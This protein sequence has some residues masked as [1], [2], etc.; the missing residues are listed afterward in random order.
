MN[1]KTVESLT[2]VLRKERQHF[3]GEFRRAE[4]H[5]GLIAEERE[6]EMEERA[7][8][9][10]S[11]RLLASLDDRTLVAVREIDA[12]LQRLLD[13]SYGRCETVP[14]KNPDRPS[15]RPPGHAL[16]QELRGA[17]RD[18]SAEI[19]W[20]GHRPNRRPAIRPSGSAR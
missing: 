9:E 10:G 2:Q 12:A 15:S 13:E 8:E 6:S 19:A 16:L 20:G 3:L 18:R 1:K 11:A 4:E 17:E 5:L 7:Q 14:E